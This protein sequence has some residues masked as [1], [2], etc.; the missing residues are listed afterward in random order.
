MNSHQQPLTDLLLNLL[1]QKPH[2]GAELITN[3]SRPGHEVSSALFEL[4]KERRIKKN[5][6]GLFILAPSSSS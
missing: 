3:S 1:Q 5:G 4:G 6:Q 2:T